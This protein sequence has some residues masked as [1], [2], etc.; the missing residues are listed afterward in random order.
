MV[1]LQRS[2]ARGDAAAHR[3]TGS[4]GEVTARNSSEKVP[5]LRRMALAIALRC[6]R[7]ALYPVTGGYHSAG[8]HLRRS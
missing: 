1:C 7:L 2:D 8:N 5:R 3:N 4:I 6:S